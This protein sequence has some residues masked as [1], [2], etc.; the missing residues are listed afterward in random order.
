MNILAK[1]FFH[2]LFWAIAF[3]LPGCGNSVSQVQEDREGR[4]LIWHPFQ[5][6]EAETLNLILDDYRELYPKVKIV[7]EFIPERTISKEFKRQSQSSLGPDLMISSYFD[8]IPL[9]KANTVVN[10]NDY[11]L[12]NDYNL[13]ISTYLEASIAQVIHQDNLYGL[14]F[15]LNTQVLCYNKAKVEQP[16]TTLSEMIREVEA[17]QEIALTSNFV[18]TLWGVEIFHQQSNSQIS[19]LKEESSQLN[20]AQKEFAFNPKAWAAWLTWLLQ[21]QKNPYLILTDERSTLHKKFSEEKLAYYVCKT[22]E[23][24]DLKATLGEDK[25]GVTNLPGIVTQPSAPLLFTRAVVFNRAS[26]PNTIKLALQLAQFLTNAQQQTKLAIQTVSLIP[27]NKKVKLNKQLSPIKTVLFSQS[28]TAVPVSLDYL[29]QFDKLQEEYGDLFY[30]RVIEGV[31]TP[32]EAA[33]ELQQKIAQVVEE[34]PIGLR[35]R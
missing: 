20:N 4:L 11:N 1:S 9:I 10:L 8:L 12:K 23:I 35:D 15:S 5:G 29:Y 33:L 34:D 28:K 7:A 21:A 25:L 32:Q 30:K 13:D 2:F 14:P 24:S 3:L 27:A 31:M 6:R 18:D 26:S 17:E 22:E 19:E 16:L